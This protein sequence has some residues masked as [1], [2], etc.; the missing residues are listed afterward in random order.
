[1]PEFRYRVVTATGNTVRGVEE[2]ASAVALERALGSRGF[3]PIEIAAADDGPSRRRGTTRTRRSDVVDAIRYLS[4]LTSAGFPLDR[5]LSTVARVVARRD[6]AAALRGV[7]DRVRSG[8]PLASAFGERPDTFPRL[9]V[10]MARAGER[11]G[12]LAD[13]LGRLADH[14]EREQALRAQLISA[15]LYPLL[16]VV[17]GGAAILVLVL[18]VLPRFVT[19]L[20]ETGTALPRSTALLLQGGALLGQW[21]PVLLFGLVAATVLAAAARRAPRGGALTDAALLRL[22]LVAPLRQRLAATR[23]GRSLATL[24]ESGLPILAALDVAAD[25]LADRA[26]AAQV[27]AARE[28]VRAGVPLAMALGRGRAFPYVFLK[29]VELGEEG[30]RLPE[31]LE[32]AA[33]AAELE[34]E[35]GLERLA[36]LVEPSLIV[37]FGLVAG[38]V[39]LSLLQAIYGIRV[40]VF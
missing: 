35:R 27:A 16:M 13:A 32:R 20:S 6:V 11:G 29:M 1:M 10:G 30:G 24:L 17:V 18:Y 12:Y 26:A 21:W 31:M 8:T 9:A 14:L 33:T 4:T 25:S 2:A 23:F 36:R 15:L 3:Y 7:R 19:L 22:P 28:E 40:E 34:L 5:A 38:F 39:A 37:L